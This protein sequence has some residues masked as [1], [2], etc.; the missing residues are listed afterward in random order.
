MIRYLTVCILYCLYLNAANAQW[1][2]ID[3]NIIIKDESTQTLRIQISGAV[4]N[5]LS[6]S[7]NQGVCGIRLKFNHAF[8]GDVTMTLVSP[9]GQ[10]V[11]LIGPVGNSGSTG[12]T[13]WNVT[14]VPC[15]EKAI[16]DP[17][18]KQRWDNK[19]NWGIFNRYY[20]GT[21]WPHNGCLENFN[22]GPVNGTWT[23]IIK[24]EGKF[25]EG[26]LEQFC[27]LF[28]DDAGI[29]CQ[30]CNAHGGYFNNTQLE[31]CSGD[32]NL[33]LSLKP[34]Q[35]TFTP[36]PSLYDYVYF[37]T[38]LQDSILEISK[39]INLQNYPEGDY[40]ICGLSYLIQDSFKLPKLGSSTKFSIFR[41]SVISGQ[42][43]V[44][45]DL[46]KNC[47][48]LRI[49][50]TPPSTALTI[51]TCPNDTV[52]VG[53]I[54]YDTN[55]NYQ[56][57]LFSANGCDSIID[58]DLKI[59][60][61]RATIN[62][63]DTLT[64]TRFNT[65]LDASSSFVPTNAR[66]QWSTVNG[67]FLDTTNPL[68]VIV[69]K[70]GTYKLLLSNEFCS[71]SIEV[72][73]VSIGKVID[74]SLTYDTITCDKPIITARSFTNISNPTWTW[75]NE[76]NVKI[77]DRDTALINTAGK[78]SVQI[79]DGS[80]CMNRIDFEVIE[81]KILPDFEISSGLINCLVDSTQLL[82][83]PLSD[84]IDFTWMGPQFF[85][86]KDSFPFVKAEGT[87]SLLA[88]NR[89]GCTLSKSID[90]VS[91][92]VKPDYNYSVSDLSCINA[93][94]TVNSST[95]SILRE[96]EFYRN[97]ISYSSKEF[98]PKINIPGRYEVRLTDT[99][100]CVLDTFIIIKIDTTK[101][102]INLK[103]KDLKCL[104][105]SVE[106]A[107]THLI[108]PNFNYNYSWESSNGFSSNKKNIWVKEKGIYKVTI[109]SPN[110]CITIDSV[111]IKE[112]LTR[113]VVN[114]SSDS[115]NCKKNFADIN[116][117][118][119]GN[120]KFQWL[121][122]GGFSSSLQNLQVT[123]P[124]LYTV[125]VTGSNN[126]TSQR[127]IEVVIDTITPF[128]FIS[129][130]TVTCL[131]S[132]TKFSVDY[133]GSIQSI[134]WTHNNLV[135]S[136]DSFP[137]TSDGG[138]YYLTVLGKNHCTSSDSIL[139]VV[140]TARSMVNVSSDSISCL[141][142]FA[143]LVV[144]PIIPG[145][146]YQWIN[147]L[148]DTIQAVK[149]S[150]RQGGNY[151]LKVT[152]SNGCTSLY[153]HTVIENTSPPK[154][155]LLA[156]TLTCR[157]DSGFISV[158][159]N[160]TNLKYQ[161]Q[162]PNG[163][164]D[165]NSIFKIGE[166]GFYLITVTDLFGCEFIDSIEVISKIKPPIINFSDTIINC[167]NKSNPF[168]EFNS[169]D[170]I[171]FF[172]W[173]DPNGN[174]INTRRINQPL[175]GNYTMMA[176]DSA[177]CPFQNRIQIKYDTLKN[178]VLNIYSDTLNCE[179]KN[180]KAKVNLIDSLVTYQW[181][182][183]GFNSS[184]AEPIFPGTGRYQVRILNK[185]FCALDTFVDILLDT[186]KPTFSIRSDSIS[187]NRPMATLIVENLSDQNV[188]IIW[189]DSNSKTFSG[190]PLLT[191]TAGKYKVEV[192][193]DNNKCITQ[194]DHEV[195][196]DTIKPTI[197][198]QDYTLKCRQDSIDLSVITSCRDGSIIWTTPRNQNIISNNIKVRDTG[199]YNIVV[200][201]KN[202]CSNVASL[203]VF[204]NDS[205]PRITSIITS[206]LN[207][208]RDSVRIILTAGTGDS[209]FTWSG[210]NFNSNNQN[211]IVRQAGLYKLRLSNQYGCFIDTTI[212]INLDTSKPL[213]SLIQ[214]DTFRCNNKIITIRSTS[215]D[216]LTNQFIWKDSIGL[217][218]NS[219]SDSLQ[220]RNG[221]KYFL[222]VK[223]QL[224]GCSNI[225]SISISDTINDIISANIQT[226]D[227]SC[228]NR[229]DGEIR[230]LKVIGGEEEYTYSLDGTNYSSNSV[231]NQ[232]IAGQYQVRIRDK[233]QCD[234][235]TL[236]T[237]SEKS[238][239]SLVIFKDA[240]INPGDQ[241]QLT[242]QT[243]MLNIFS[244]TWQPTLGLSCINCT[245]PI[246]KPTKTTEYEL[247][248]LDSAGCEVRDKVLI[249]VLTD[250][251][252]YTPDVYSPNGD[253]LNDIFEF[254]VQEGI[255]TIE[256]FEV[257]DRWG[258]RVYHKE[259]FDPRQKGF[260]WSGEFNG[261]PLNPG[262]FVYHIIA[263]TQLGTLVEK[264]G[265]LTLIR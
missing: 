113:P 207:C 190:N 81:D 246:A 168:I 238:P 21:Y 127:T 254:S 89:N 25:Q 193:K 154:V 48:S 186:I 37:V 85:I 129:A 125:T 27:I 160:L 24:D 178:Q 265:N 80:G 185:N 5:N 165:S 52:I 248:L 158:K 261:K 108:N 109:I 161:W 177:N 124:G 75:R 57:K 232:L 213:F 64:C 169:I 41:N 192:K 53:G 205:F 145:V 226:I 4:N 255:L 204:K 9:S 132:I 175:E 79:A 10:S 135:F 112:D 100:G 252:I 260:G 28:C 49:H 107:L 7:L 70:A 43:N 72:E 219:N 13:R 35:P 256:V 148:L 36:D 8:L 116:T 131:K 23:L 215:L 196:A 214:L 45:G 210:P 197:I 11:G 231:F 227:V 220:I 233:F 228:L 184:L 34:V 78:Y 30:A 18:I 212:Q 263:K 83:R 140:D 201:C 244:S 153:R 76:G 230:I 47:I 51:R 84:F 188:R 119:Q 208:L 211:P 91:K 152:D 163:S 59:D 32:P 92:I 128:S 203:N 77:S 223:S 40:V 243:N 229:S 241:I 166:S 99:S 159:T 93:D 245:Q 187:C 14:F 171:E 235:D 117:R 50:P 55:G 126:C 69:N 120:V 189:T 181:S 17:K 54:H 26:L 183:N 264:Y 137:L 218:L 98:K 174:I 222:E 1:C 82:L 110:G 141:K 44:C 251:D 115:I 162:Y 176:R 12:F 258:A 209:I 61:I 88:R 180:L 97:D 195:F 63:P 257:Y 138:K 122:P 240:I 242:I 237:V 22:S 156:D 74:L 151:Q 200:T 134:E 147:T 58:L 217:I 239:Y 103:S 66:I 111:E 250:I 249:E 224:T 87:Y 62:N 144:L 139:V 68:M 199:K 42:A 247:I 155:N 105:D 38:N 2:C 202:G 90:V 65:V 206:D 133:R 86:S 253:G 149:L 221:G 95:Q 136:T 46:S 150:V 67:N 182:G 60:K 142:N 179:I 234:Y 19:Q 123:E 143:D 172:Q 6:D 191:S 3:T 20:N 106:I 225:Q 194:V 118:T 29:N 164:I 104:D 96:I 216:P 73:V 94:V 146:R 56:I 39:S 71:D 114:L 170:S 102:M 15:K 130:D 173:I 33:N 262:V 198:V 16:P 236:I 167:K 101:A 157:R 31:F 259:N 121:G